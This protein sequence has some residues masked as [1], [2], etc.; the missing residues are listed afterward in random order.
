MRRLGAWFGWQPDQVLAMPYE[1][2]QDFILNEANE[3]KARRG[4]GRR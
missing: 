1:D 3:R 4:N 2:F